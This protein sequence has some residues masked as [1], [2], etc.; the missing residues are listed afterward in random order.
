M[1]PCPTS[2]SAA[3][4][5]SF[6]VLCFVVFQ[7]ARCQASPKIPPPRTF[8]MAKTPPRSSHASRRGLQPGSS[9]IPYAP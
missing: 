6:Q 7:P 5:P 2:H 8:A 1:Y 9:T 4:M 3:A